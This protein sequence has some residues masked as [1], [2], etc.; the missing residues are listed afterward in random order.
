MILTKIFSLNCFSI[1]V[2]HTVFSYCDFST[3]LTKKS[4]TNSLPTVCSGN[5]QT[6]VSN[7]NSSDIFTKGYKGHERRQGPSACCSNCASS[8]SLKIVHLYDLHR[9]GS[10]DI[11]KL[12][13]LLLHQQRNLYAENTVNWTDLLWATKP[14]QYIFT[15]CHHLSITFCKAEASSRKIHALS[16][17]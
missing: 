1:Y 2:F 11:K 16:H 9:G 7:P 15:G 13:I 8:F 17:V 6:E 4:K 10:E 3:S 5:T 12:L 14:G